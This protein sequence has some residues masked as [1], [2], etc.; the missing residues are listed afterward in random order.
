[1]ILLR[2]L[3][4]ESKSAWVDSSH[5]AK[6]TRKKYYSRFIVDGAY[7]A[8]KRATTNTHP[9]SSSPTRLSRNTC[10]EVG[11]QDPWSAFRRRRPPK[12]QKMHLFTFAPVGGERRLADTPTHHIFTHAQQLVT[13]RRRR[14]E[15]LAQRGEKI[16]GAREIRRQQ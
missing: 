11:T 5:P 6:N 1:M 10:I 13:G 4:I 9:C 2:D 7:H 14:T 3:V 12:W 15:I 16:F 8:L